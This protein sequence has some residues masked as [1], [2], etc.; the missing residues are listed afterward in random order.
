MYQTH[1]GRWLCAFN[2]T[3]KH[4]AVTINAP[5]IVSGDEL[6]PR[7]F[8]VL[9]ASSELRRTTDYTK[10]FLNS[11]YRQIRMGREKSSFIEGVY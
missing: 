5:I 4:R 8:I 11:F 7:L 6:F 9:I 2:R 10:Y 3:I 1:V